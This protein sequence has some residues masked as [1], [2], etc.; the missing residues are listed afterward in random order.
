MWD[1]IVVGFQWEDYNGAWSLL[2]SYQDQLNEEFSGN[3]IFA[4]SQRDL[5]HEDNIL[6]VGIDF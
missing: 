3:V 2:G 4:G 5:L 1:G 6:V